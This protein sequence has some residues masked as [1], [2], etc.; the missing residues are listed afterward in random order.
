MS[1]Q[2]TFTKNVGIC[3]F[4]GSGK[5]WCSLYTSLHALSKG[6]VVLLIALLAKQAIQLGVKHWRKMFY[7]LT[8]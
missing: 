6:L 4:P 2:T 7:I 3:G 8:D 1:D 5:T